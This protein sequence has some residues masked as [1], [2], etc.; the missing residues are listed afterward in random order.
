VTGI[1][2]EAGETIVVE[3]SV[4]INDDAVGA[5][6]V[7]AIRLARMMSLILNWCELAV[8]CFIASGCFVLRRLMEMQDVVRQRKELPH[9]VFC[10]S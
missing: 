5:A 8:M 9:A 2:V 10:Q 3:M 1:V 7:S 4:A 6:A